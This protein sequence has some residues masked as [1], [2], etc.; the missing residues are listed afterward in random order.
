MVCTLVAF[1]WYTKVSQQVLTPSIAFTSLGEPG[2]C[3]YSARTDR[4][5]GPAVFNEMRFA[6]NVRLVSTP[7]PVFW[8]MNP[9]GDS[10]D[11]GQRRQGNTH[12]LQLPLR[13]LTRLH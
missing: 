1:L 9:A 10:G 7:F 5:I 12:L 3:G 13:V 11:D 8:L 2:F 6:L 4:L